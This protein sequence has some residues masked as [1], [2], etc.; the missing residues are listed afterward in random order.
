ML[1]LIPKFISLCA[2][3]H[4]VWSGARH[5]GMVV[6][7]MGCM[8]SSVLVHLHEYVQNSRMG[9]AIRDMLMIFHI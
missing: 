4:F 7:E 3:G 8:G 5:L 2:A 1:I 9:Q 6:E